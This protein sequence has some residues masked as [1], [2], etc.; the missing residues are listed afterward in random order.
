LSDL[1]INLYY[2]FSCYSRA[3]VFLVF[4]L[5]LLKYRNLGF[6]FSP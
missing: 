5:R 4:I 3:F 6:F 1:I 2:D